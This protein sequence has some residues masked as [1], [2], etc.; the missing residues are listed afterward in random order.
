MV[1]KGALLVITGPLLAGLLAY[2]LVYYIV[3]FT[4]GKGKV[5]TVMD[6]ADVPGGL[7][8]IIRA[9]NALA[10]GVDGP[11]RIGRT[12]TDDFSEGRELRISEWL[13]FAA[14]E[15]WGRTPSVAS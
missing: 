13:C 1:K 2:G 11:Q 8:R 10:F 4:E 3:V 12:L 5:V 15:G 6:S 7:W 14:K 9:L